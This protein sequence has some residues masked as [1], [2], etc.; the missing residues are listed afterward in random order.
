MRKSPAWNLSD[1]WRLGRVRDTEFGMNVS[2]GGYLMP[3]SWKVAVF[4]VFE[5]FG[6]KQQGEGAVKFPPPPPPKLGL[7]NI[8]QQC[9]DFFINLCLQVS[10]G[11]HCFV[12][13]S[14]ILKNSEPLYSAHLVMV[15]RIIELCNFT[16]RF[17]F[18]N[19]FR[20]VFI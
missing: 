12:K 1:I 18:Q 9:H 13:Y 8:L 15:Y 5:L 17:S 3:R 11:K 19:G 7:R 14:Q 2:N 4:T 6:K 16:V 10:Q 20:L